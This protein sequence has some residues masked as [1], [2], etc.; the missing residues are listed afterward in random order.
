MV[1]ITYRQAGD[2]LL[3]EIEL[4]DVPAKSLTKYGLM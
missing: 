4:D 3:P 2:Y 1:E